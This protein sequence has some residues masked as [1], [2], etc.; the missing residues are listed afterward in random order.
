MVI[1][2]ALFFALIVYSFTIEEEFNSLRISF[3]K[4]EADETKDG[5]QEA[6]IVFKAA[7][8]RNR[9]SYGIEW[10]VGCLFIILVFFIVYPLNI[11]LQ[12]AI[13]VPAIYF[14]FKVRNMIY[15]LVGNYIFTKNFN[16]M[17]KELQEQAMKKGVMDDG[18]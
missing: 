17:T 6:K 9:I 3:N 15:T 7:R 4:Q 2:F 13:S 10:L 12:V 11:I 1:I 16:L 8:L 5:N 14:L 18:K